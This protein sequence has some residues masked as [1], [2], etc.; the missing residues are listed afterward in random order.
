MHTGKLGFLSNVKWLFVCLDAYSLEI[1]WS[2]TFRIFRLP[3]STMRT[4]AYLTGIKLGSFL[5]GLFYGCV[6]QN[7]NGN[8]AQLQPGQ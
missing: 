5:V 6:G 4:S 7:V 8:G 1:V 3:E 2:W